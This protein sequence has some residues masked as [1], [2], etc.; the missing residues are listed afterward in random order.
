M[1]QK[2]RKSTGWGWLNSWA[3]IIW[4]LMHPHAWTWAGRTWGQGH[5][6][7]PHA[8]ASSQHGSS[9]TQTSVLVALSGSV[10]AVKEKLHGLLW[11]NHGI[12]QCQVPQNVLVSASSPKDS[13]EGESASTS[14]L[15]ILTVLALPCCSQAFSGCGARMSHCGGFSCYRAWA[16]GLS[17]GPAACGIFPDQGLNPCPLPLK[18]DT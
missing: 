9:E 15:F 6:A 17:S 10:P 11:S 2:F 8:P 18:A 14:F 12:K 13:G 16:G 7:S 4:R 5:L 3:G 1:S